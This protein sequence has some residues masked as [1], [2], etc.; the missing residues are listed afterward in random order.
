MI[1]NLPVELFWNCCKFLTLVDISKYDVA[2]LNKLH[3]NCF[4]QY[5]KYG[6][7]DDNLSEKLNDKTSHFEDW[8]LKRNISLSIIETNMFSSFDNI[9][10]I[11]R[12]SKFLHHLI[13]NSFEWNISHQFHISALLSTICQKTALISINCDKLNYLLIQMIGYFCFDIPIN[14][15]FDVINQYTVDDVLKNISLCLPLL[16]SLQIYGCCYSS[17]IIYDYGISEILRKCKFLKELYI[18]SCGCASIDSDE[19]LVLLSKSKYLEKIKISDSLFITD[20]G[21]HTL[22][23]MSKNLQYVD[24]SYNSNI[25]DASIS[26]VSNLKNLRCF[27]CTETKCT[28]ESIIN[29][30]NNCPLLEVL[31]FKHCSYDNETILTIAKKAHNLNSLTFG[32]YLEN[33]DVE[34]ST[35]VQLAQNCLKLKILTIFNVIFSLN[36]DFVNVLSIYNNRITHL[37][38]PDSI[39]SQIDVFLHYFPD[40]I[41]LCLNENYIS[42]TDFFILLKCQPD[43]L[44]SCV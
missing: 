21:F 20:Y 11:A 26:L 22:F 1:T 13:L 12:Q 28:G 36:D 42:N 17:H 18:Q 19:T 29:I 34:Y 15:R 30:V 4:L 6:S 23:S 38:V 27:V 31:N 32:T 5:L 24:I 9:L 16:Q 3:R 25:G 33:I 2:C 8:I 35:M 7:F 40:L 41:E 10:R 43:L 37:I 44:F 39:I 14:I